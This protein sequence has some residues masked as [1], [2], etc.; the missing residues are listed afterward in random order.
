MTTKT[1]SRAAR[2]WNAFLGL[3]VSIIDPIVKTTAELPGRFITSRKRCSAGLF[4]LNT[5]R[6]RWDAWAW[7]DS[8]NLRM[9]RV[10][11]QIDRPVRRRA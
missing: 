3:L 6:P 11:L 5:E 7:P 8:F 1:T 4:F 9:G 2:I 10:E